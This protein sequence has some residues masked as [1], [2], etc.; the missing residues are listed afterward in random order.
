MTHRYPSELENEV[1]QSLEGFPELAETHIQFK[2][3]AI[4]QK[5]F[6]LAQPLVSTLHR[7]KQKRG[8][9]IIMKQRFFLNNPNIEN[10]RVPEEVIVGWL[11]HELGHI[12]D[13]KDRSSW[14][15]MWFGFKYFFF[16]SFLKKAEITADKNAV[17]RGF[18]KE[19]VASKKFGRDPNYFPADYIRKLNTYYPSI[20]D[21]LS[22]VRHSSKPS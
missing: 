13:Y 16:K 3:G 2:W 8:Y 11:A 5:S 4:A 21:V 22:W 12:L 19:I 17:E 1:G 14:N 6:M 9:Q 7:S 15:L 20:A 10:G 18:I